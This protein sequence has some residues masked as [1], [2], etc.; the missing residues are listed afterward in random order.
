[1]IECGSQSVDSGLAKD[2]DML[3][4]VHRKVTKQVRG[5]SGTLYPQRLTDL[6][7]SYVPDENSQDNG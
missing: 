1:M 3:E 6:G 2:R 7:S 5:L 4:R